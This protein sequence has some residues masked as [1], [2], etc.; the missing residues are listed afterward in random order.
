[1]WKELTTGGGRALAFAQNFAEVARYGGLQT[2]D[3]PAPYE[4]VRR[5]RH[6]T[7]KHYFADQA[8]TGAPILLVPSV[9]M[10]AD[11]WDVSETSSGVR[12]LHA[13]GLDPWVVDF[14]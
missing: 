3:R 9:L 8:A 2:T 13:A 6:C 11:V 10:S 12:Q 7:L 14:G 1:M 5:D 4:V